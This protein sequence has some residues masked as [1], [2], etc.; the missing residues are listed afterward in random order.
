MIGLLYIHSVLCKRSHNTH[1]MQENLQS[2]TPIFPFLLFNGRNGIIHICMVYLLKDS[3]ATLLSL[4]RGI[5]MNVGKKEFSIKSYL[6]MVLITIAVFFFC[7]SAGSVSVPLE[8]TVNVIWNALCGYAE[9]DATTKAIILSF[10]IP[11]VMAVAL[12]GAALSLCGGAM[13]GLL[14]NPLADGSTLGVSAGASLGACLALAFGMVLPGFEAFGSTA[15]AILFSFL[16]MMA[17]LMLA[18]RLDCSLSTNTIIL[19]G[20]IFSMFMNS[21]ISLVVTFAGDRVRTIM[22]WMMGSLAGAGYG[23]ALM[24]AVSVAVFGGIILSCATQLNAFAIGEDNA[25]QIGVNVKRVKLTVLIAASALIGVCVSVGGTIGF[26]GLVI[27]HIT[28]F[29]TG[30]NH[31]KLLPAAMFSGAIF[32]MLADLL[33]RVILSPLELPIGVIT[34]FVGSIVFVFIFFRTREGH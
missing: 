5:E 1:I 33:A 30:P 15:M 16:S 24:L 13:Q 19:L 2:G 12:V 23:D 32:L 34:S 28:R 10:R 22:F 6:V 11:R 4:V 26:V 8:K 9:E 3:L 18:Y 21:I 25:R 31:K 14:R 27:P 17:V 7:V 29:I 20:V